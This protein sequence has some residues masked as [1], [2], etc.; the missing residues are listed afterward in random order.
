[1]PTGIITLTDM[2]TRTDMI[3][4]MGILTIIQGITHMIMD[5]I[6]GILMGTVTLTGMITG[7]GIL[8]QP[9]IPM[10][11]PKNII[12]AFG[13]CLKSRNGEVV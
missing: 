9:T 7:M 6:T 4:G 11:N 13:K 12:S 8:M 1:M 2:I 3:T 10:Q 5:M